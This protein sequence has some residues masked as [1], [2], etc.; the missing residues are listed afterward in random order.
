MDERDDRT[1]DIQTPNQRG[2][3]ALEILVRQAKRAGIR[4]RQSYLRIAKQARLKVQRY[5]HA[6]Q[7]RRMR[8]E[9]RRLK[10][11]LGRVY[12]DIG[13]KIAG[14][15]DLQLRVRRQ[16]RDRRHQ[17]RRL[18]SRRESFRRYALRRPYVV[19]LD[20]VQLISTACRKS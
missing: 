1:V 13:R 18:H 16:G 15:P 11:Y 8:R 20:L 4:L 6:R 19:I 5:G 17:P 12:R 10:T 9:V 2:L 3:L 14:D 7:Y